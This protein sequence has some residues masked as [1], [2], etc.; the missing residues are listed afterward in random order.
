MRSLQHL[1][2]IHLHSHWQN[3]P[4]VTL[5]EKLTDWLYDA[6]SLTARLKKYCHTFEVVVIGQDI[7]SCMPEEACDV[8][9][10][11]EQVLA[12]EVLLYCD[13]VPQVFARSLLP[14]SSLTGEQKVL[15]ELGNQPLG[16][17]I[18]NN[19]S[20]ERKL[21]QV[22]K[23]THQ[24]S[25]GKL[26]DQLPLKLTDNLWGRRSL[27]YLEGKPLVVAEV[28]LPDAYAYQQGDKS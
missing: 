3:Y 27:F 10:A 1:F 21:I 5:S 28:F 2:P 14:L 19:P 7:V 26:A 4:P 8:V 24:N 12:R 13:G 11:G 18:F 25:I 6:G 17:I 22:A 16:H 20:L 15:A 23:F 9:Q